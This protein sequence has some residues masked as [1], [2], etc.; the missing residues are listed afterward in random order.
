MAKSELG[1]KYAKIVRSSSGAAAHSNAREGIPKHCE[2]NR[3][4]YH[5]LFRIS[6]FLKELIT[7]FLADSD[8]SEINYVNF[9][10]ISFHSLLHCAPDHRATTTSS[11]TGQDIHALAVDFP[12][13]CSWIQMDME[14]RKRFQEA[15]TSQRWLWTCPYA[16]IS[17]T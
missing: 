10:S 7:C 9:I 3:I 14:M 2:Q 6:I 11:T 1:P 17:L 5:Y 12:G 8:G 15:D 16:Q 4:A 13:S